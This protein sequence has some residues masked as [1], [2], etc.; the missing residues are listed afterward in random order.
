M[1]CEEFIAA[2]EATPQATLTDQL[3]QKTSPLARQIKVNQSF[4]ITPT[5]AELGV[6]VLES[7]YVVKIYVMNTGVLAQAAPR[8][9]RGLPSLVPPPVPPP[10][11]P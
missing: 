11:L 1:S 6:V 7:T 3:G 2:V 9:T 4:A 10:P 8:L 5:T